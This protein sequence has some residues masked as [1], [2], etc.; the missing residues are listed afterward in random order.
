[1]SN[2]NENENEWEWESAPADGFEPETKAED[3]RPSW[4][5]KIQ[6]HHHNYEQLDRIEKVV[7][8]IADDADV[9]IK[10]RKVRIGDKSYTADV[11]LNGKV[12][13]NYSY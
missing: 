1:M 6:G 12:V 8:D 11:F 9:R 7:G 3:S 2:L 4:A 13:G 10:T 5:K